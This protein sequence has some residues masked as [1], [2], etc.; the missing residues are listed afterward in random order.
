MRMIYLIIA[1][2]NKNKNNVMVQCTLP[3]HINKHQ[4]NPD[5]KISSSGLQGVYAGLRWKE[6]GGKP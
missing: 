5:G 3:P 1:P 2:Q 4:T 6:L